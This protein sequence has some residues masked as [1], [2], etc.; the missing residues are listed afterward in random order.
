MNLPNKLTL[1]RVCLIPVFLALYPYNIFGD[2]ASRYAA[3]GVFITASLTD[4][5]DGHI[6]RS[7]NLIT[8]FGKLMDP[9]ADKLLVAAALVAMVQTAVLPAWTVIIIIS[10][11]F[12]ITGFRMLALERNIV[13]AASNWGKLKTISQM[14]MIILILPGFVPNVILFPAITVTVVLTVVSAVDYILINKNVMS[15]RNGIK[16]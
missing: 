11:E 1:L 15:E 13:I 7:R 2:P 16:K 12:L 5:L 9:M 14:V 3:L 8:N 4:A 10:R 6:A